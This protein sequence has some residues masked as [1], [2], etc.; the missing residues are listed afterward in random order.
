MDDLVETFFS[1]CEELYDS[2]KDYVIKRCEVQKNVKNNDCGTFGRGK[3]K[4]K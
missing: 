4:K 1:L 3:C 2:K